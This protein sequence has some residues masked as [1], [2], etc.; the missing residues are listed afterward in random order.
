[1]IK[2]SFSGEKEDG[3]GRR[4]GRSFALFAR[5]FGMKRSKVGKSK[6]GEG[7]ELC[8]SRPLARNEEVEGLKVESRR[9]GGAL[10]LIRLDF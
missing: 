2:R 3:E 10:R 9:G 1:M 6:V 8:A 7:A 4:G 5:W